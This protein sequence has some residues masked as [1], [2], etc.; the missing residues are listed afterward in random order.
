MMLLFPILLGALACVPRSEPPRAADASLVID[1]TR[2]PASTWSSSRFD[3]GSDPPGA[4]F[5]TTMPQQRLAPPASARRLL[6][7]HELDLTLPVHARA[8]CTRTSRVTDRMPDGA[9]RLDVVTTT[10][11]ARGRPRLEERYSPETSQLRGRTTWHHDPIRGATVM[12]EDRDLDGEADVTETTWWSQ[13]LPTEQRREAL[14]RST[15][16]TRWQ[17]GTDWSV[18]WVDTDDDT[19]P[20]RRETVWFDAWGRPI[21]EEVE[22]SPLTRAPGT[23]AATATTWRWDEAGH[24]VERIHTSPAGRLEEGWEWGGERPMIYEVRSFNW[25]VKRW[26]FSYSASGRPVRVQTVG[27]W[28]S[29]DGGTDETHS[30]DCPLQ[31]T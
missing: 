29:I 5:G 11:D 26:V 14:G 7:P 27:G 10:W 18:A 30:W 20:D 28:V 13:G 12:R 21:R 31:P 9:W 15:V 25:P 17:Y 8:G 24:L 1:L 6:P 16:V 22:D 2:M 4:A 23:R 19:A 3:D